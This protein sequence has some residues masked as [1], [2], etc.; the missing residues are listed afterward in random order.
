VNVLAVSVL[1]SIAALNVAA[2]LTFNATPGPLVAGMV[3]VTVGA[4]LPLPLLTGA[5][6]GSLPQAASRKER[7]KAL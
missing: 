1:G 7:T 4:R 2:T 6:V 5:A 3:E